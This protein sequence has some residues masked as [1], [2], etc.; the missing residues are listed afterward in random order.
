MDDASTR[1]YPTIRDTET[2]NTYD[3]STLSHAAVVLA[4][5]LLWTK[6]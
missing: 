1:P 3:F 6:S 4:L 2:G 5:V